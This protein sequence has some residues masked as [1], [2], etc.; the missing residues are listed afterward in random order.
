VT[1]QHDTPPKLLYTVNE[2]AEMLS[3]GR[4]KLYNSYILPGAIRSVK[5]GRRR[6]FTLQAIHDFVRA[7]EVT[8]PVEVDR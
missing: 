2:V 6:L 8:S 1:E 5:L 3:L 4:S 7:L